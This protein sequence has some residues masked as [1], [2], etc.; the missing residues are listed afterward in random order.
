MYID[1]YGA[2]I[3]VREF[4]SHRFAM[5]SSLAMSSTQDITWGKEKELVVISYK[6]TRIK[7]FS[8]LFR[9]ATLIFHEW[10]VGQS[11]VSQ[12]IASME[13]EVASADG[14]KRRTP[15]CT[16]VRMYAQVCTCMHAGYLEW[17]LCIRRDLQR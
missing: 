15:P 16:S 5:L 3:G 17:L 11:V 7:F 2:L 9:G 8:S 4:I 13:R 10:T 1:T 14:G 12:G 6:H